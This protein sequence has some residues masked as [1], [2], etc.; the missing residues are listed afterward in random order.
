MSGTWG[1]P[2]CTGPNTPFHFDHF[3][4]Y[5]WAPHALSLL[6]VNSKT[7]FL[8]LYH[9]KVCRTHR[10][11]IVPSSAPQFDHFPFFLSKDGNKFKK[12]K[13][14]LAHRMRLGS[15]SHR[16]GSSYSF[17]S[18]RPASSSRLQVW[19][20]AVSAPAAIIRNPGQ[21][22]IWLHKSSKGV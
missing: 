3:Q 22:H 21:F 2:S 20:E 12:E 18:V 1:L 19:L 4:S 7:V 5:V 10:G 9:P 14:L 13:K 15:G 11:L 17:P 8:L 6:D 16:S